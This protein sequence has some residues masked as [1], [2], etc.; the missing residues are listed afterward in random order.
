MMGI[1]TPGGAERLFLELA[2][3]EN[4]TP[5][6]ITRIEQSLGITSH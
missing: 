5:A 2:A 4:P 3:L 6:D 1:A